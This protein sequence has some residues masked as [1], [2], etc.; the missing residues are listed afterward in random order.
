MLT[1][2][3]STRMGRDKALIDV[4]GEAMA[5]RVAGALRDAGAASVVCIGGDHEGL[6]AHGLTVVDDDHPGE[7]PLGAFLTALRWSTTEI[8]LVSPCDLV[9][10]AA[11]SFAA[12]VAALAS[13]DA[14]AAVPV[15]DGKARSMP[16]ALRTSVAPVLERSFVAGERAA[17]TVIRV[18]ECIEV[19]AGPLSDADSPEDLR[20]RR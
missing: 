1:G 4:D 12:L 14:A 16:V 7:G 18:L 20:D 19:D 3:R 13:S 9:T 8:T 17:Y 5:V 15:V 10:P 2:G 11:S 6:A